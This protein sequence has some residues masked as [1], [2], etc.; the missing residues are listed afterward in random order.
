VLALSFLSYSRCLD[1][2]TIAAGFFLVG[3]CILL[4]SPSFDFLKLV[5]NFAKQNFFFDE[6]QRD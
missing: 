5:V 3:G 2:E 1:V 4:M 6:R